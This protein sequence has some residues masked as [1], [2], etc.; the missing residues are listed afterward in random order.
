[1]SN[2]ERVSRVLRWAGVVFTVAG[3]VNAFLPVDDC[4]NAVQ[5]D[6]VA[7]RAACDVLIADQ[8]ET[9]WLLGGL[10]VGL[11]VVGQVVQWRRRSAQA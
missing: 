6:P 9:V 4:G 2:A 5:P 7:S 3:G 8:W 1:M 11:M 10:G